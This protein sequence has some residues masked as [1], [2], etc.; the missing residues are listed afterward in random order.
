MGRV[1]D[2]RGEFGAEGDCRG[3]RNMFSRAGVAGTEAPGLNEN[4]GVAGTEA[5]G[6]NEN[7]GRFG[8]G[9][10]C[11]SSSALMLSAELRGSIADR[12][13]LPVALENDEGAEEDDGRA[14]KT[15]GGFGGGGFGRGDVSR[16]EKGAC[17]D[18]ISPMAE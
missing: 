9:D 16:F 12:G 17:S 11:F 8:D 5:P 15:N 3:L 14:G 10:T 13:L 1:A 7:A 6:L 2:N 4:A 18:A